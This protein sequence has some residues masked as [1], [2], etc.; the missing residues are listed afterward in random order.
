M[1]IKDPNK[2]RAWFRQH[3]HDL[4]QSV[5]DYKE[6]NPCKDCEQYY[7]YYVMDF[8]HVKGDKLRNLAS[9][10][11]YSWEKVLAEI[12]K[13]D[14]VCSNCHRVRTHKRLSL[15]GGIADTTDL[16]SVVT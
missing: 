16:N 12:E 7:P 15:I 9:M 3:Y 14:L 13:C 4:H 5:R 8:D 1:P 10:T 11:T 2:R 6:N